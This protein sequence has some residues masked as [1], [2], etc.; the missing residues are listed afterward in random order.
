MLMK[1]SPNF[2]SWHTVAVRW[3]PWLRLPTITLPTFGLE[4]R[5]IGGNRPE[6]ERPRTRIPDPERTSTTA[7]GSVPG[8]WTTGHTPTDRALPSTISM[9]AKIPFENLVGPKVKFSL[10][11]GQQHNL[12]FNLDREIERQAGHADSR[13]RMT[14][15]LWPKYLQD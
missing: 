13:A 5:P 14:P 1:R 15:Y 9:I 8:C 6:S 3:R 10:I 11:S 4:C 12:R 7:T 2:G